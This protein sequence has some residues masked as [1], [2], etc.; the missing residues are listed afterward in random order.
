[1]SAGSGGAV[2]FD[3]DVAV[4]DIDLDVIH[5]RQNTVAWTCEY[6]PCASVAGLAGR[7]AHRTRI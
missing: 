2:D 3:F 5:L 7:E 4:R 6:D 1:L